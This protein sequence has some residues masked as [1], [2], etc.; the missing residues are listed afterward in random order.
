MGIKY[1]DTLPVPT[2][3]QNP[4]I[5]VSTP[6]LDPNEYNQVQLRPDRY[7]RNIVPQLYRLT[8]AKIYL[9]NS[10][11]VADRVLYAGISKYGDDTNNTPIDFKYIT[12]NI[13]ASQ[14]GKLTLIDVG[15]VVDCTLN[16]ANIDAMV[17]IREVYVWGRDLV[18][19][20]V[21][22][23]QAGDTISVTFEF[24]YLNYKLG[25]TER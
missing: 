14:Q 17:Q 19:F 9:L 16:G 25:V 7:L 6:G 1:I 20:G 4:F 24:E 21:S 23:P 18:Y 13:A 5:I 11:V 3:S 2:R 10:A 8:S 22:N 15:S 12:G